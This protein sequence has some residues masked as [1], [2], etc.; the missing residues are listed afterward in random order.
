MAELVLGKAGA[1]VGAALLPK[2]LSFL[3]GAIGRMAGVAIDARFLSPPVEGPRVKEFHLTE[4]REGTAIPV[5]YGRCRVG[6]Q[7]IWATRFKERRDVGGGKGGP[8]VA[9]YSY[10]LSFAV[11]LC[12]GEVTRVSRCWA[13]GEPFDLSRV[14]WRLYRG[15]EDQELDPLIEA[16]EVA[17]AAP[18]YRGLAYIVFEDMPVDE[19]GARMPQLSFEVIRPAGSGSDR[20]EM[21]AR[22]VNMIP[23]SGEFALATD[24]VRRRIGPGREIAENL[25]GAE[26]R[27]DFEASLEQLQAELPNVSRVNLVVAWFGSDLRCGECLIRPGVEVEDKTT[28]PIA[29]SVVGIDRDDA[30]VVSTTDGRSNYGGTPSDNSVRQAVAMLQESGYH[31]TLY[32]FLLM[33]IPAGNSL[34][35]PH[36][37]PE[38]LAFPWRGRIVPIA[39]DVDEQVETFFGRYRAFVLHYAGLAEDVGAEGI[40]IGSELVGLTR[41][42]SG[43]GYPAVEALRVLAEDVRG[44][45]GPDVEISYAADWTEYG[46]HV[47]E[48]DVAFPLDALWADDAIDYIGLDWYAPM[49][50]WRDS[51]GHVDASI[52]DP[53]SRAYMASNIAGGEAFDWHYPDEAARLAQDRLTISDGDY[54]EPWVFRQK[55]ISAWWSHAHHP[56]AGG[57]RSPTPTAWVA[58]MKPVRF[59]EMGCP[60]VDKGA[61]QPNVFYDPKSSESALPHFSDGSRDDLVQRRAIEAFH[62]HW[63]DP[64]NNLMS[65]VYGERMMPED[66][67]ALW[68]WDAR[69]FPS[70][71]TLKDVWG[72]AGNWR[73][74]HW[75]NGRVGPALLSDVVA[76]ICE[77]VGADVDVSGLDGVVSGYSFG[78]P[79]SA[80]AV[81]EPLAAVYGI[82]ATERGGEIAFRMRDVDAYEIDA[83]R[84]VEENGPALVVTRSGMEDIHVR[85]R[86]RFVDAEADHGPGVVTSSGLAA[87]ELVDVEAAIALDRDQAERC[88]EAL[89]QQITLQR[90]QARFA[91]AADGLEIEAGDVVVLDGVGW[92]VTEVSQGASIGFAAVRAGQPMGPVRTGAGP[93]TPVIAAAPIEPDVAIVDG[94][95]LPGQEDDLRPIGFA[96]ADPW[97][98]PVI[99]SA[100]SDATLLSERGRIDRPC[101]MGRLVSGLY[102][103]V[104]GRWQ[105]TSV[106]VS[107]SGDGLSSRSENAVLNGGNVALVETESG[108]EM[109][110]F[111]EAALVDAD[112]YKLSGLLRGQ[113]GS[114]DAL[115]AGAAAGSRIAFLTGSETRL[116][117]TDWERGLDLQWRAGRESSAGAGEWSSTHGHQGA[118]RRAWSPSHLTATWNGEDLALAWIRRARKDGDAWTPGEPVHEWLEAYRIRVSGGVSLRQWDVS[119]GSAIYTAGDLA[120]DFPAGGSALI[121]VAQIGA[122]G[123]PGGWTAL[124]M[125]IPAP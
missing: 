61:N 15:T 40:L 50:D 65:S 51:E 82:D 60:A 85:V 57:A 102:P 28:V 11:A 84:L 7:L 24:V 109:L 72:D 13:N 55:D 54:G 94:P 89:A 43:G 98:G 63:S 27:S 29:W 75:L 116:G 34:P 38:Q 19:F 26:T 124:E 87:A 56:R 95:P 86:L 42:V 39:G 18:A 74:G 21:M 4:S 48:D 88:A 23:G 107:V 32:P 105:E 81:L 68:A 73:L 58:G 106:W 108:W 30:Y 93:A 69:P 70:F 66:G 91:M 46:A 47:V 97:T 119:E 3:G 104:S 80:R 2:G 25:H 67:V 117:V 33:D 115:A 22:G 123:E 111:L 17:G 122:N 1:A 99:F 112:T 59:V 120:T 31:V 41:A 62:S 76:D 79:V 36:G 49:A 101:T 53:R 37:G 20:L 77:R 114:E 92:R 5:V 9:T 78:G 10:S 113:Q 12:E 71:P 8:R 6:G 64:A 121:E 103:H 110:Q 35:D 83:G 125:T 16:I 14:T 45:V 44:V 90:E 100:G 96:F 52:G 118:A